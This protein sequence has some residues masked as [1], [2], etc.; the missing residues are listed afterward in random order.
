MGEHIERLISATLLPL[1]FFMFARRF[2][3]NIVQEKEKGI[4]GYLKMNGMSQAAY[5]IS[6][7]LHEAFIN[8]PLICVCLDVTIWYKCF[9]DQDREFT[10]FFFWALIRF[11]F[12]LI[13][14]IIAITAFVILISKGFNSAGFATQIGSMLYLVPIF[15]TLYLKSMEMKHQTSNMANQ[16]MKEM[17]RQQFGDEE[18]EELDSEAR[19]IEDEIFPWEQ[20]A[21]ALVQYLP[22]SRFGNMTV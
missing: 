5:N 2:L 14:F 22:H 21:Q 1:S 16:K 12:G 7:I 3:G 18:K 11:N 4:L 6:F 15:L 8:G 19:I 13:L 9:F 17:N 20:T 10:S